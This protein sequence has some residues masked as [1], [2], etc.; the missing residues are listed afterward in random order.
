MKLSA[1][2][3]VKAIL[4]LPKGEWFEYINKKTRTQVRVKSAK[5]PEG[6]IY[7]ER[8][9]PTRQGGEAKLL[10]LSTPLI[11]RIANA[12]APNIPINFDRILAGSYN[13]RSL[14]ETLMAHTPQFYWCVPGRIELI[15]DS[16]KIKRGHKH[17]VWIPGSPHLN[18]V[19]TESKSGKDQAISEMPAQTIFYESLAIAEAVGPDRIQIDVKRRHLQIQIALIEIGRQLGFRTWIAHGDKGFQYGSKK[20]GELEGV[21]GRLADERILASYEEAL[22]AAHHIDCIWFKNG[23]LMPAVMEVE[24]STGVISGLSR[25]KK[26]Q[27]LGPSLT[28][29]RWVIVA[30]DEDREDVIRKANTLQFKSLDTKYFSYS[31]VEELYSLCKKRNLSS[32]AVTESFLDCFMEPC[33]PALP[34]S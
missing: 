23:Q 33:L 10:T 1:S 8:R 6:P 22:V 4:N 12:H 32:K 3:I 19:L 24:H 31:S 27:D 2:N 16:S 30:P 28:G 13:N 5:G 15:H 7:V 29:I 9:N 26:F 20:V 25:M 34:L 14:L 11:W 17:L 18:G 21:I